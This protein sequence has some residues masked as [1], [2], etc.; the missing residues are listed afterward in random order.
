M[1]KRKKDDTKKIDKYLRKI[2]RLKEKHRRREHRSRSPSVSPSYIEPDDS[3]A[4]YHSGAVT[5][6]INSLSW[7]QESCQ[8]SHDKTSSSN[9]LVRYYA[10]III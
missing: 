4:N 5:P 3:D 10:S 2:Q 6:C 1:P 8:A 9:S 7:W